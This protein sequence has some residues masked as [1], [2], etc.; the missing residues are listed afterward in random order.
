VSDRSLRAALVA[1]SLAGA[2]VAGYVLS[3]RWTDSGLLCSTGGCET[4][5]SSEYAEL[6]GVP[7]AAAGLVGYVL[8]GALALSAAPLMRAAVAALALAATT[9]SAYLLVVQLTVIHAVCDWCLASDA[10]SSVIA[11]L[12]LVRLLTPVG[13]QAGSTSSSPWASA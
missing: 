12:A 5:Q 8:I 2:A 4:V 13:S 11:A 10:I 7:V 9:F 6:F 1:L 3:S